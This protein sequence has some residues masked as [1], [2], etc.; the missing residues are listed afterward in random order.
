MRIRAGIVTAVYKKA[1]KLSGEARQ[2]S[3]VGE[4]T[5]AFSSESNV[6]SPRLTFL[7]TTCRSMR[8]V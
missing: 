2:K 8:S 7:Q 4:I 3:T 1:F 6:S 5:S